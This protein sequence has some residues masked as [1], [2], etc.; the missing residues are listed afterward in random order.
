VQF[1]R[2][3]RDSEARLS[4][5]AR[6]PPDTLVLGERLT[7]GSPTWPHW[8]DRSKAQR[9]CDTCARLTISKMKG[10]IRNV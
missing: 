10:G 8:G 4:A 6:G 2:T 1:A 3:V 9:S 5:A 7:R